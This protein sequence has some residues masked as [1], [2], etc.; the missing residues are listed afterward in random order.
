MTFNQGTT[1]VLSTVKICGCISELLPND[2]QLLPCSPGGSACC[3]CFPGS[4]VETSIM[5]LFFI[6]QLKCP[7]SSFQKAAPLLWVSCD[8]TSASAL[9]VNVY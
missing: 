4:F 8:L 2:K 9:L 7:S 3:P 5:I 1:V 6:E